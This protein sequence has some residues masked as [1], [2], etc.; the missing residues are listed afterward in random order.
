VLELLWPKSDGTFASNCIEKGGRCS[1]DNIVPPIM[2]NMQFYAMSAYFYALDCVRQLGPEPMHN[3]PT[4]TIDELEVS[5]DYFCSMNWANGGADLKSRHQYTSDDRLPYRCVEAVYIV[6][7]LEFG[8]G[9]HRNHRNVTYALEV[10]GAE[11][12]WALGYSLSA[13]AHIY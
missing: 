8:F 6:T 10:N 7:L 11:V 4:P 5:I 2:E 9:F 1:V 13:L 3:W 12:E